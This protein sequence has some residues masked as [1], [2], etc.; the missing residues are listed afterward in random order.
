MACCGG[1]GGSAAL[2]QSS[3]QRMEMAMLGSQ[4]M[5][6]IVYV[7]GNMGTME[8]Y[9]AVSKIRYVFGG[10][11]P[12]GWVDAKDVDYFVGL[13]ENGQPVFKL[14]KAKEEPE[15]IPTPVI[16]DPGA[17]QVK[18]DE[19]VLTVTSSGLVDG[20]GNVIDPA[21]M[22]P[23]TE[24]QPQDIPAIADLTLAELKELQL[25]PNQWQLM[26]DD[27]EAGRNRVGHI[28]FIKSK[29]DEGK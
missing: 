6:E 13:R 23:R 16:V 10:A 2:P 27:E 12:E 5:T 1:G 17:P 22:K 9:G 21:T 26:F 7:G 4:G 11:R 15:P 18:T 19:G 28:Q 3:P 20:E 14:A 24:D 29:L 8:W 25:E